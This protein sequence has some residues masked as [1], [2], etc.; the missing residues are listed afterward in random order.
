MPR[1]LNEI[2]TDLEKNGTKRDRLDRNYWKKSE[3]LTDEFEA[4]MKEL[5]ER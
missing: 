5:D 2:I 3:E 4:L 1:E